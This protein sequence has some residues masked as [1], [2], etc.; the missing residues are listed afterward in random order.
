VQ[1]WLA[2]HP[3]S[4][5]CDLAPINADSL[6]ELLPIGDCLKPQSKGSQ[7]KDAIALRVFTS[8]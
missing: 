1:N 3:L 7:L 2:T 8:C 4:L 6:S 5:H